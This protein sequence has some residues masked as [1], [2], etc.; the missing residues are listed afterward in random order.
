MTQ[1]SAPSIRRLQMT[2]LAVIA[3]FMGVAGWFSFAVPLKSAAVALGVVSV[4][5]ERKKIQHLE[6][7]IIERILVRNGDQVNKGDLLVKMSA[8]RARASLDLL[9]SRL[10]T[11]RGTQ[12]R[13]IAERDGKTA[14]V[15]P[16]DLEGRGEEQRVAALFEGQRSLFAARAE[17][18]ASQRDILAR[19]ISQSRQQI[20]GLKS[21][22]TSLDRQLVLVKE[23]ENDVRGLI[24]KGLARKPRLL[25]LERG[26]ADLLG[27]KATS[28]SEI[29]RIEQS[30]NETK[31]R[32]LE[33]DLDRHDTV[34]EDLLTVEAKILDLDERIKAAED[35]FRRTDVTAP[36]AGT[37]VAQQVHTASGVVGPGEIL[38]EIVPAGDELLVEARVS[39]DDIDVVHKGL[40]AR[41]RFTAFSQRK[42]RAVEAMV[43]SVSA[44]SLV[45]ERTGM[46]Y[47]LAYVRVTGDLDE[48]IDGAAL[49]PGMQSQV[50][51]VTGER[52]FADYL[53]QPF[54]HGLDRAFRE[55]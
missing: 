54:L 32:V 1:A 8:T 28:H 44:D 47:F 7:G 41:V 23:E 11:A 17:T 19:Q 50:M 45:D 22:V 49:H 46:P 52:T 33:L 42:T 10:L 25:A 3:F 36:I 40:E 51:I 30:I 55:D 2:S 53:L 6:G 43:E 12:A 18:L 31:M 35:L 9:V 13:L 48:A 20:E 38:M 29:A 24:D 27:K 37:I 21:R 5:S 34:V 15:F 14:I 4:E 26:Y 39:P 16:Q